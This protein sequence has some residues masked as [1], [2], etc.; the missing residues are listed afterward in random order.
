M[1]PFRAPH[2]TASDIAL[3]D[4]G[5]W[6]K[7]G[8]ISLAHRGVLFLD[9]LPE[10]PRHVLE[11]LRQP[12]EDGEVTISRA[13]INATYPVRFM[14]VA[15]QNPCPCG[16]F[17][18]SLR[19]CSYTLASVK[20]YQ[21]KISGPLLDRIDLIVDVGRVKP[22]EMQQPTGETTAVVYQRVI[23]LANSSK[24]GTKLTPSN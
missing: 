10:F 13:S 3:I 9:E 2:H 8:E 24:P 19:D 15:A 12:L 4:G 16:Y 23:A 6:P 14:L 22:T 18:D 7:P 21:R 20:R 1:R 11:V 5:K 17:G